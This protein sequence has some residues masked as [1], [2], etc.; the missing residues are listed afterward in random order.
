M[1][2]RTVLFKE[3]S[4]L[5][6]VPCLTSLEEL[7]LLL[8]PLLMVLL[9]GEAKGALSLDFGVDS[10]GEGGELFNLAFCLNCV[11]RV[12]RGDPG[13]LVLG[14]IFLGFGAM[15]GLGGT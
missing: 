9:A 13:N 4:S 14:G 5:V 6:K 3:D 12:P 10:L 2:T 8:L 11:D 15:A 1:S 7:A